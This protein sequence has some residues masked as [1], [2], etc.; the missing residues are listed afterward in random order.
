MRGNLT[1]ARDP[2]V[3]PSVF[4]KAR[5]RDPISPAW[6]AEAEALRYGIPGRALGD[7]FRRAARLDTSPYLLLA[8]EREAFE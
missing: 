2:R 6:I 8:E 1:M 3:R 7:A 4:L 5:E